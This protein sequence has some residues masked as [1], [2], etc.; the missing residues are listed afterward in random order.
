MNSLVLMMVLTWAMPSLTWAGYQEAT[1]AFDR[2]DAQTALKEFQALADSN[3]AR[4]QYGLGIMHDLGEGVP[5]SSEQAAKWYRLA[6]EQDYADAQNN[7]GVMYENGEGVSTNYDEAMKWY[8]KAAELGNK[9]ALNNIGVM[10]M[11]GVGAPRDFVKA[12]MWFSIAGKGDPDAVSNK[13]YLLKRMTP[14]E[15][16]QSENLAQEWLQIRKQEKRN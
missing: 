6:A 3:D 4:G 2:G 11:T 7:L 10:H 1:D 5:Q 9:D 14:E 16:V 8:R 15:I 12:C 13:N